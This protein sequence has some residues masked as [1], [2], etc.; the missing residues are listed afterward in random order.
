MAKKQNYAEKYLSQKRYAATDII[1]GGLLGICVI[2][3]MLLRG[4]AYYG[5]IVIL[6]STVALIW[7]KSLKVKD[8]EYEDILRLI[9]RDADILPNSEERLALYDIGKGRVTI[10]K[11]QKPRSAYWVITDFD[12]KEDS[13]QITSHE[14][15]IVNEKIDSKSYTAKLSCEV[16]V[17][18]KEISVPTGKKK[19]AYVT[20]DG[21]KISFPVDP[22]SVDTDS[23]ISR[24][25]K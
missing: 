19:I 8:D 12:F 1:F 6:L 16:S 4:G 5:L 24:L 17:E 10:G 20:L 23:I 14:I 11:D 25:K 18:E 15:D 13:C 22:T 3:F 7:T 2:M 21:G 9:V